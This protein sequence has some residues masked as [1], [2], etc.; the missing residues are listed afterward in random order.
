MSV[1]HTLPSNVSTSERE[2]EHFQ[3]YFDM[4]MLLGECRK[5]C[6]NAQDLYAAR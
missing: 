6:R 3:Q 2:N 1:R 5:H 4:L